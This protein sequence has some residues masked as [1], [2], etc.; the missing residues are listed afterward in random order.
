MADLATCLSNPMKDL[1]NEPYQPTAQVVYEVVIFG[2]TLLGIAFIDNLG[3][4][5]SWCQRS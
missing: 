2:P 1:M 4:D 5:A 3:L